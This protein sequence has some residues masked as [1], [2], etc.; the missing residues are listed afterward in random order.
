LPDKRWSRKFLDLNPYES[1]TP[2]PA[3]IRL[4]YWS[5]DESLIGLKTIEKKKIPLLELK[6]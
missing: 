3:K 1:T 5:Q 2:K 4:K 6:Q